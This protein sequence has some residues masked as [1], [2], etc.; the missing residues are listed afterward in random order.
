MSTI[1]L[2]KLIKSKKMKTFKIIE[3]IETMESRLTTI[4]SPHTRCEFIPQQ[5][6][7]EI[8]AITFPSNEIIHA[9]SE[10]HKIVKVK[11]SDL[12]EAPI[13]NWDYNRPPDDTR[14]QDIARYIYQSRNPLDTMLYL[15]FSNIKKMFDVIDGIHR[16]TAIKIISEYNAKPLDL[17]TS[18]HLPE[19]GSNCDAQWLYNS[20]VILNIRF[21]ATEETLIGLFKNLNKSVSIP[22]LYIRDFERE[23]RTTI[24]TVVNDWYYKYKSHFSSNSKPNK[25]NVNR[26]RFIDLLDY[27]YDKHKIREQTKNKLGLLV[28][29]ANTRISM[30]IPRK[31]S[32]PIIDKCTASG[33]WLFVYDMEKL[34]D[35]I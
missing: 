1:S 5:L 33:C 26:D 22:E 34:K 28:Q 17:L 32:I 29:D 30:N 12:L 15:S 2:A 6:F 3:S 14:C 7:N 27:L 4:L 9:Y 19:F 10:Y 13:V 21:N 11:V 25:P 23:K 16:F 8:L 18:E 24:E 31:L 35:L 20:Y